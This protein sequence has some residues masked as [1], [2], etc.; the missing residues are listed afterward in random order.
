MKPVPAKAAVRVLVADDDPD[1]RRVITDVLRRDGYEVS[2]C[3]DGAGVIERFGHPE[4]GSV[5]PDVVVCDICMP[6]PSG[7]DVVETL[8]ERR[9]ATPVV[10]MSAFG[11]DHT[12]SS[13]TDLGAAAFLPK[14]F[15]IS[16]LRALILRLCPAPSRS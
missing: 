14:P 15:N 6:G 4:S 7:F 9:W 13:A 1:M 11:D 2:E 5:P 10:L 3:V 8:R 16:A 12:R